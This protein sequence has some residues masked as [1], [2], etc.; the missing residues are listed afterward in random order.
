MVH[1]FDEISMSALTR[2]NESKRAGTNV[3]S[4]KVAIA[5]EIAIIPPCAF[6]EC[7]S[8]TA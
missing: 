6:H 4:Q 5:L 1:F 7:Q 2:A 3:P 8:L